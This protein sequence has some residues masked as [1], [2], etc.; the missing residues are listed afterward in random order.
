M[1]VYWLEQTE[2]N[3]P[4]EDNWFSAPEAARLSGMRFAKRRNDWRLG[5]WTAKRALAVYLNVP[6]HPEALAEIEIRPAPSG[7]PEVF[8]A[9]QPA[10]V[11]VSLSHR[12]RTAICAVAMS[13]AALGCDLEIIEPRSEGFLTDFFTT[14][15]E[16]L[17]ARAFASD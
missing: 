16:A 7:A 17:V 2:A 15:E 12:A 11:T 3:V 13:G 9:N 6:A 14:E 1:D 4:A 5:R 10:P 8:F